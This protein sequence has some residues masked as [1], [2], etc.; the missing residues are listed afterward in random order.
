[1]NPKH[2]LIYKLIISNS[3]WAITQSKKPKPVFFVRKVKARLITEQLLGGSRNIFL[4][5]ISSTIRQKLLILR[6]QAIDANLL[7]GTWSV[8][9][10]LSILKLSVFYLFTTSAKASRT[11]ELCLKL[12]KYCKYFDSTTKYVLTSVD[13]IRFCHFYTP[14]ILRILLHFYTILYTQTHTNHI[15]IYIYI[16]IYIWKQSWF[17]FRMT[18]ELV[19][20]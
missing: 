15:Y 4:V 13:N 18:F 14:M 2:S 19:V 12:P 16:Y 20:W 8:S 7:S 6:L 17:H 1:M 5:A 11:A 9:G 10:E 3:K